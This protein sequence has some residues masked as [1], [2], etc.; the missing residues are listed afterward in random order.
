MSTANLT[1]GISLGGTTYQSVIPT[2]SF[3]TVTHVTPTTLP[4]AKVG[5]LTT[6]TNTTQGVITLT[7]GHGLATGTFNIH[8]VESGVY[9]YRQNVSCT[10]ATNA[11]TITGGTGDNLPTNLNAVNVVALTTKTVSL[12]ADNLDAF[13]LSIST[14]SHCVIAAGTVSGG[15][16]TAGAVLELND[17]TFGRCRIWESN[18][19]GTNPLGAADNF[20]TLKISQGDAAEATFKMSFAGE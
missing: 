12:N 15:T 13:A 20:T 5:Q 2:A 8:W 3:E 16:F 1:V 18:T 4:A 11:C 14:A 19:G 9:G 10:I 17:G 6:R 7:A